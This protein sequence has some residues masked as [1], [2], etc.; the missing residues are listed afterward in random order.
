MKYQKAQNILPKKIVDLIQEYMDGGYI[1]IPTKCDNKKAWGEVSGAKGELK[2]RNR[3]I[4]ELYSKG[5]SLKDLTAQFYLTERSIRR[6]I[7]LEKQ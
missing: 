5:T 4:Y 2:K 7:S 6:I 3:A 1:Y